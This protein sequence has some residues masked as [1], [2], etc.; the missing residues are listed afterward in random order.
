MLE[1]TWKAILLMSKTAPSIQ[2]TIFN[3]ACTAHSLQQL[4]ATARLLQ[5]DLLNAVSRE[6]VG[7]WAASDRVYKGAKYKVKRGCCFLLLGL[8]NGFCCAILE[9]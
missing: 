8:E 7:A 2:V 4:R 6:P 9:I 5:R 3:A 1:G